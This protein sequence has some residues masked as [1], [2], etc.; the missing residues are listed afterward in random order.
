[1]LCIEIGMSFTKDIADLQAAR[2]AAHDSIPSLQI[3]QSDRNRLIPAPRAGA[4]EI[5]G[6]GFGLC[7]GLFRSVLVSCS[8]EF[9]LLRN[10]SDA[11]MG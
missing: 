9:W 2:R 6:L 4:N 5:N 7:H 3:F 11:V 1:M 10:T 8:P